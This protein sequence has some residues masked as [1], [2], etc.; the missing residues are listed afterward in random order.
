MLLSVATLV[1]TLA[2]TKTPCERHVDGPQFVRFV[3]C[4]ATMALAIPLRR[5]WAEVKAALTPAIVRGGSATP[6]VRW[7]PRA[8]GARG[9]HPTN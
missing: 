5:Q 6:R 1:A 9:A 3:L 8:T 4:T 2:L 7:W